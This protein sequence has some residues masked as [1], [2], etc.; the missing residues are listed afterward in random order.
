MKINTKMKKGFTLIELL[1]V[2]AIIAILVGFAIANLKG[3]S[4]SAILTSMKNDARNAI[5]AEQAFFAENQEY[6][7]I[8]SAVPVDENGFKTNSNSGFKVSVS[9]GNNIGITSNDCEDGSTGFQITVE[10]E[11]LNG[12]TVE[13]DSCVN[14]TPVVVETTN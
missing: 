13:F 2:M 10:N 12:K 8:G 3:S 11:N 5:A 7:I 9:K 6:G 4:N 1:F 14:S